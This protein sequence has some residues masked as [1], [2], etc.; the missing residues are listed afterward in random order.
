LGAP[1]SDGARQALANLV[2][3]ALEAAHNREVVGHAEVVRKSEEFKSTLLD[4]LAHELRT[5]LT[6]L[7]A[8]AGALLTVPSDLSASQRELL[9]IIEEETDRLNRLITE[10][11]QMARIEAGEL[12]LKRGAYSA[13]TLVREAWEDAKRLLEGRD[14]RLRI[15]PELPLVFADADLIRTVLKHLLDNAAKYS[16]PGKPITIAVEPQ[17]ENVCISVTDQGP[18]LTEQELTQVFEKYFRGVRTRE[19]VPGI[20]MGLAIARDIIAAHGGRI[21]VDRPPGQG[22]RFSFTLP[23]VETRVAR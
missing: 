21:W 4:A 13:E 10:V 7:Q 22:A 15:A 2:A 14:V 3:I 18:G 19:T 6:S 11:L 16:S 17:D 5:P 23:S 1:L 12:R 9:T 8:S 20:G